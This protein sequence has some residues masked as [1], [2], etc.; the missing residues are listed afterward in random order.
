[1]GSRR[2]GV[3]SSYVSAR[4]VARRVAILG[5]A[6]RETRDR[7]SLRVRQPGLVHGGASDAAP[8]GQGENRRPEDEHDHG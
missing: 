3:S 2:R 5:S 7:N 8:L 6:S 1:M 4:S